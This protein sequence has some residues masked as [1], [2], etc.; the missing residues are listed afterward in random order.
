[1]EKKQL[2]LSAYKFMQFSIH[3]SQLYDREKEI[4][5]YI[6]A[7]SRGHEAIQIATGLQLLP[8]D[9]VAPYYRDD[10]LMLSMGFTPYELILQLLA[11]KD[12]PF[13]AG[14]TYYSHPSSKRE[15]KPKIPHQS[16]AT[17]MQTIPASGVALGMQY[18]EKIQSSLLKK[19]PANELPVVVCSLGDDSMTE[20]EVSE[21]LQF[22]ALKQLPIVF[23]VQDNSWGISVTSEESRAMDAYD[24]AGGFKGLNRMRIDGSNFE[25]SFEGMAKALNYVR[26]KRCP[27]L[28]HAVV[29]LLGHHNSNV[30]MEVYRGEDNLAR[31]AMNDPA[32]KLRRRLIDMGVPDEELKRLEIEALNEV[33]DSFEKAKQAEDPDPISVLDN[34]FA[35]TNAFVEKG[36]RTPA[37]K[38]KVSMVESAL[39]AVE[40]IMEANPECIYYGQ[41]VGK[42]LG[43]MFGEAATLENKFG[44]DRVFNTPIQEAFIIGSTVGLSAIGVKPIVEIQFADYLYPGMNQLVTEVSKSCY[45]SNGKFPVRTLIRIPVGTSIGGGPYH[46]GCIES[47]LLT[48]KGIKVVYPSN[49]ADIKGLMKAAFIDPNPVIMLEHKGL[50]RSKIPGTQDAYTIEPDADYILPLGKANL[51][52]QTENPDSVTIITYGLGV[53]WAKE[54]A[55]L[56]KDKVEIID[57]RTLYPLDESLIFKLVKRSGRCLLLSEAPVEN[58]FIQ[59]LAGRIQKSCFEYLKAP[60]YTIGA[61]NVPGLPVNIGL[62]NSVLPDILKISEGINDL[63][64]YSRQKEFI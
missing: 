18:F 9:F 36:N 23:L 64:S 51:V 48:I 22:T 44:N 34:V 49:A 62:E 57:L 42:R 53:Y 35:P 16:S 21:A 11:K 7:S 30:R 58:S 10:S 19:G 13:S 41:D 54:A 27:I 39:H 50:Y 6:Y 61:L 63:L 29:P 38:S 31:H 28:V 37:N 56:F 59:A 8:C 32:F 4:V 26:S 20:G 45:L 17:G 55:Q 60:I 15:D 25:E 1:M 5:R 40:E 14:R 12:D 43:G 52:L 24:F 2:L 33:L 47:L 3:M 46:S